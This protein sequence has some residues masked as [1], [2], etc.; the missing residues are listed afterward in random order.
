MTAIFTTGKPRCPNHNEPLEGCGFP[1]P[2]KGVGKCPIS[3]ADFEFEAEVDE[4]KTL[5]D[6]FG[7][8]K[9]ETGFRVSGDD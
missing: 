9:K 6:K 8:V 7:N 5:V 1:L 2:A 4:A 3:G